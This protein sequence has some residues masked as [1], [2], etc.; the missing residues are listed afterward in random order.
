MPD[1]IAILPP[2]NI[3]STQYGIIPEQVSLHRNIMEV[4]REIIF[5]EEPCT[6]SSPHVNIT[7]ISKHGTGKV[8]ERIVSSFS[9]HY[10]LRPFNVSIDTQD[11]HHHGA[12]NKAIKNDALKSG[13]MSMEKD[14]N[15]NHV[16]KF[17]LPAQIGN[18]RT[19]LSH[20]NH[21]NMFVDSS[22]S[23]K[24]KVGQAAYDVIFFQV[25]EPGGLMKTQG[26]DRPPL[27]LHLIDEK[28]IRVIVNSIHGTELNRDIN[29]LAC[30]KAWN[31]FQIKMTWDRNKP[32]IELLINGNSI[33]STTCPFGSPTSQRHYSK[34]GVYIPN[35]KNVPGTKP[36]SIFFDNVREVHR[37]RRR[38]Q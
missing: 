20:S 25:R 33:F 32:F 10:H 2:V 3:P 5:T 4:P 16:I 38:T 19:E 34:F 27:S 15:H 7:S 9:G 14:G 8:Q 26:R 23:F 24:M 21:V 28:I 13:Y 17:S 11:F 12:S 30:P 36:T 6:H 37:K 22:Y 31:L 29:L 1:D 18:F 35:Q